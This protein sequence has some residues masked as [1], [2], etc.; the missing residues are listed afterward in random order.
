LTVVRLI[1]YNEESE[2]VLSIVSYPR[3]QL[4]C[5]RPQTTLPRFYHAKQLLNLRN[6]IEKQEAEHAAILFVTEATHRYPTLKTFMVTRVLSGECGNLSP[7]HL[8]VIIRE[9]F[10]APHAKAAYLDLLRKKHRLGY[11]DAE[12]ADICR[13]AKQFDSR[14][15][16]LLNA[17]GHSPPPRVGR[18]QNAPYLSSETRLQRLGFR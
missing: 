2:I 4:M 5:P 1:N 16:T 11:T 17:L 9:L 18:P 13:I 3:E 14:H 12:V 6:D 7:I 8:R 10:C 15:E